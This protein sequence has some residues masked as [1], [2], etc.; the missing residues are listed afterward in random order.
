MR[1]KQQPRCCWIICLPEWHF[2]SPEKALKTVLRDTCLY[3]LHLILTVVPKKNGQR[4]ECPSDSYN[5]ALQR[6]LLKCENHV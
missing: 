4:Y 6:A 2:N 5:R 3:Q 1:L